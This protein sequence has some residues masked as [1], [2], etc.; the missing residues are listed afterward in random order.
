MSWAHHVGKFAKE[1][2]M[3]LG[4]AMKNKKCKEEWKKMKKMGGNHNESHIVDAAVDPEGGAPAAVAPAAPVAPVAP[5]DPAAPSMVGGRRR[6]TMKKRKN[7]RKNKSSN[8]G[9]W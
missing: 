4:Q 7:V 2:G 8:C 3:K 9:W 1:N 6:K 5:A